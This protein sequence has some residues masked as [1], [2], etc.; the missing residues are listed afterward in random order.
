MDW[1]REPRAV[2]N[3][4]RNGFQPLALLP[5]AHEGSDKAGC[6]FREDP[7]VACI[8]HFFVAFSRNSKT[9]LVG[10][11]SGADHTPSL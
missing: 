7:S 2:D 4:A 3:P 5:S 8:R 9:A 6:A 10:L 11:S 1:L